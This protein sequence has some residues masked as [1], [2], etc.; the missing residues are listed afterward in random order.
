MPIAETIKREQ[1]TAVSS[2]AFFAPLRETS[3]HLKQM[4]KKSTFDRL[5]TEVVP[6]LPPKPGIYK[7]YDKD[8]RILYVGK[9][10]SLRKRVAS[11]FNK[12]HNSRK[13]YIM[14]RQIARIE[15]TVTDTEQDALLLENVLI[16]EMQPKYNVMLKDDKTYPYICIKNERFPR[17]F[18]TRNPEKDGSEYLGPY[19]SVHK[20]RSILELLTDIFQ[21]R[22][23]SYNLSEENIAAGKFKVCLEYHLGNCKGPCAGLQTGADYKQTIDQ[24]RNILKGNI[25]SV[26]WYLKTLMKEYAEKFEF[27]A[28]QK[29]KEKLL[30]LENYQS[31][32]TVVNPKINNVDVF[33]MDENEKRAY[34]SY[35][36]VVN[37]TI[38]Q[39]QII[40]LTKKLDESSEQLLTF[41]MVELRQRFASN[42]TEIIAPFKL[43]LPPDKENEEQKLKI[44]VPQRGDKKKL[45]DFAKKNAFYYRKQRELKSA[46]RKRPKERRFEI[47]NQLKTDLRLTELPVHI[48]CFDNSNFQGAFPVASMVIFREGK[49]ANKE[50]RHF[51]IKTVEGIDDFASMEEVVYR[52][53]KRLLDEARSLPQLIV[54]DGGKGQLSAAVKSL[55]KL[56]IRNKVAIIGIAK[57][58]EEIYTPGDKYPLYIDKKSQSLKLIQQ[59]RNEAH[60]FAITFHRNKRS[61]NAIKSEL[62]NIAGIGDKSVAKLLK[63]FKSVKN[64]KQAGVE[65]LTKVVNKRQANAI[66]AYFKTSKT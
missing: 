26:I 54:I 36:K 12:N 44:S 29:I 35:L 23:C 17:I 39:T 65:E 52:R 19:T 45:L 7:Y 55:D 10:K 16:K 56:D 20:A 59:V 24:I 13:T 61:K 18:L 42:S 3:K 4:S 63:H 37:G 41:G 51:N 9:S 34:I 28:A 27:E 46:E 2:F 62:E 60:R 58:L 5:K 6:T 30:H 22:N 25:S 50:Y 31:K 40:E 47:L 48:E 33:N 64:V 21:L 53:Y 43:R 8:D 57:K 32:S 11:Y 49:P 15:F 14:V 66:I 38:I 1:Q